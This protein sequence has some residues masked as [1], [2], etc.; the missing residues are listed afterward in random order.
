MTGGAKLHCQLLVCL[1]TAIA[2]AS[3]GG[4]DCWAEPIRVY[5]MAGQ[6]NMVGGAPDPA[7]SA[8]SPQA[9]V[10]YQYRLQASTGRKDSTTWGPLRSLAGAG[11]GSTYGSELTFAKS[12]SQRVNE[13]IAIIKVA[14]NGTNL[15]SH[16]SSTRT[17]ADALYPWM[18]EKVESALDQLV[19][20]NYQ[21]VVDAFVWVQGEG[22]S[23]FLSTATSY[24]ANLS[25]FI[26]SIRTDLGIPSLKFLINELHAGVDRPYASELR[27][28]QRN[29]A[30]AD[31]NVRIV[32][33]DDL[34]L[35]S[36]NV[37]FTSQMHMELGRRF[38][39][40]LSPSADF[41][42]DGAVNGLDLAIWKSAF[43]V[44]RQGD[45]NSDGVTDGQDFMLW[46][47]QR[48]APGG[49]PL[50]ETVPEPSGL[51]G[52]AL[53]LSLIAVRRRGSK[54]CHRLPERRTSP[55]RDGHSE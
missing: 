35:L 50:V 25:Q 51:V 42:Y 32:N 6:S 22:D 45:G 38:A 13:Q 54:A 17:D 7:P 14:A 2:A 43:G 53:A 46:Q 24:Q 47:R 9:D 16:W 26:T 19:G 49:T 15:Y 20:L 3:I 4:R 55:P 8:L 28:S 31:P 44:N 40:A 11:V 52:A 21:P 12:M 39:D 29:V 1:I 36:D 41:N 34:T 5:L 37:H 23:T 10:L 18:I 27:Q 33:A 30:A 48:S